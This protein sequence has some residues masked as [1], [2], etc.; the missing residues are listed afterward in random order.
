MGGLVECC[1][2]F[3]SRRRGKLT[4]LILYVRIHRDLLD[5]LL[6]KKARDDAA[7]SES[8]IL[9]SNVAAIT[10]VEDANSSTLVE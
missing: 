9:Q 5:R 3:A 7:A 8:S 1:G 2:L 10:V 4:C 6:R